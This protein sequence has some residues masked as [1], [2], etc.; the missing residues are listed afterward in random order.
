MNIQIISQLNPNISELKTFLE[1]AYKEIDETDQKRFDEENANQLIDEWFS[2]EEMSKYLED[3]NLLEA[4]TESNE[5]VG[6]AFVGK[7]NPITW[8]DGKKTELFVFAVHPEYRRHGLGKKLL[9]QVEEGAKKLGS[10]KLILNAHILQKQMHDWYVKNGFT[11]I[12][13]LRNYYDNG[14]AKFFSK[15]LT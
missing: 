11:E 9:M 6:V 7:Q 3:G 5:L 13:V 10:V 4:R 12:G 1:N 14:D 2:T 8:P 15:T